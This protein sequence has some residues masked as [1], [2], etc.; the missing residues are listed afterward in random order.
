VSLSRP[1]VS[2]VRKATTTIVYVDTLPPGVR[3]QVE[4]PSNG[5]DVSVTRIVRDAHGRIIHHDTYRTHYVLWNGRI[6][7]GRR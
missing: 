5:M 6:E 1:A 4:Y 7:V 2:N 3:E